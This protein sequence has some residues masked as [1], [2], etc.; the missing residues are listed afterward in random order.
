M[1]GSA[2]Q[3]VE[4][5]R[6]QSGAAQRVTA[7]LAPR[8]RGSR[9]LDDAAHEGREVT[10]ASA[11]VRAGRLLVCKDAVRRGTTLLAVCALGTGPGAADD[12]S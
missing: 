2:A 10:D 6:I 9:A 1:L 7:R 11:K 8:F 3:A 5:A 4:G 12:R